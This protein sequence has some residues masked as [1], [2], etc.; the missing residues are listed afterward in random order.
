MYAFISYYIKWVNGFIQSSLFCKNAFKT[1]LS[2]CLQA[3]WL[4][5]K[6][7]VPLFTMFMQSWFLKGINNN[8]HFYPNN[9]IVSIMQDGSSMGF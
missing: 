6:L 5:H 3:V 4:Q 1:Q 8:S 2:R 7:S 9:T